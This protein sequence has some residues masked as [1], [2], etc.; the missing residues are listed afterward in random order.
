MFRQ[1]TSFSD[2]LDIESPE[3]VPIIS[4]PNFSAEEYSDRIAEMKSLGVGSL[5]VGNGRS[6]V[7]GLSIA[8]KG[9]VGLVLRARIGSRIC[10]LK[11]RRTDADRSTMESEARLQ[12]IANSAGVGPCIEAHTKNLIAMQY[13]E[14]QSIAQWVRTASVNEARRVARSVLE[15]CYLLDNIGLDHGQLS[16]L[17]RHVIVPDKSE[18]SACIID[19]ES[20][21]MARKTNNV[22]SAAQSM[23]LHGTVANHIRMLLGET[24]KDKAI[25]KLREYKRSRTPGSFEELIHS[26]PI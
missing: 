18:D 17:D 14:G 24:D 8:G 16:R 15:Q 21:S 23:F 12:I 25:M 10:A 20:A 2:E 11:I 22:T 26:L 4:Y 6:I 13:A 3:L 19:F 5:M 7:K 9:W 1:N